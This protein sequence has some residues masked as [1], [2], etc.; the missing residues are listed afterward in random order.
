[1]HAYESPLP[2]NKTHQANHEP[3]ELRGR[4]LAEDST[5]SNHA[6]ASTKGGVNYERQVQ[7]DGG[8]TLAKALHAHD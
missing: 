2:L 4:G 3:C 6:R 8:P 1:M 7:A 5:K